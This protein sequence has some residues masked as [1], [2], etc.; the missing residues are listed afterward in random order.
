MKHI[1]EYLT[2]IQEIND[3]YK[4]NYDWELEATKDRLIPRQRLWGY[5]SV[6]HSQD[7]KNKANEY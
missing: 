6:E 2:K 7:Y 3:K 4:V 1:K 5:N